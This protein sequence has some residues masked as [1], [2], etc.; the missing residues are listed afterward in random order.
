MAGKK[1]AEKKPKDSLES[2]IGVDKGTVKKVFYGTNIVFIGAAF[3]ILLIMFFVAWGFIGDI[4]KLAVDSAENTCATL[5]ATESAL[6]HVEEELAL[7][8]GT[9]TG[10]DESLTSLSTGLD[11]AATALRDVEGSLSVL[12]TVGVSLGDDIGNSADSLENASASLALTAGGMDEHQDKISEIQDDMGDIRASIAEHKQT[13]CIKKEI[14]DIFDS[15]RLSMIIMFILAAAL[16][17]VIF[18]N[19]AAGML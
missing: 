18:I 4:E 17:F 3:L 2:S 9:A 12:S 13:V 10:L 7:V 1:N 16:I 14:T 15:I 6:V 5:I 19:S 8:S 11:Q